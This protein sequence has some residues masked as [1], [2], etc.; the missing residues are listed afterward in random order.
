MRAAVERNIYEAMQFSY[1]NDYDKKQNSWWVILS[2]QVTDEQ[3]LDGFPSWSELCIDP[4][5]KLIVLEHEYW[6]SE[7][8]IMNKTKAVKHELFFLSHEQSW[9]NVDM[10]SV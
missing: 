2:K 6:V 9:T 10:L 3:R 4:M 7:S 1:S 8:W 5:T